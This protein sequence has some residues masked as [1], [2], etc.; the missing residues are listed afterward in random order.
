MKKEVK[1]K[2]ISN[3]NLFK[4]NYI[5]LDYDVEYNQFFQKYA[6]DI[7]NKLIKLH[8]LNGIKIKNVYIRKSASGKVHIL[9]ILN[10][11]ID[12]III[13]MIRAYLGEDAYRIRSDLRK[14]W[15]GK[16]NDFMI[17]WSQKTHII[18]ENNTISMRTDKVGKWKDFYKEY[19]KY[20]K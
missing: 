9:I 16:Y 13:L 6:K 18:K 7:L 8:V 14:L 2:M 17:L 4:R 1:R 5:T 11:Y 19:L 10:D 12:F 3:K 20:L 15:K